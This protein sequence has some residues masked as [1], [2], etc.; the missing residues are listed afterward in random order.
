VKVDDNLNFTQLVP[1]TGFL[2]LRLY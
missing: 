2:K 1:T